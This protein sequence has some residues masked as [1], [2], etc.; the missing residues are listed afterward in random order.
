MK[1]L[2]IDDDPG[3]RDSLERLLTFDGHDVQAEGSPVNALAK[4]TQEPFDLIFCDVQMPDLTGPDFLRR[5]KSAGGGALVIMMSAYSDEEAAIEAMEWGAYDYLAKPFRPDQLA[6]TIRQAEERELLKR[7]LASLEAELE[8]RRS[9]EYA[10]VGAETDYTPRTLDAFERE[11]IAEALRHH[12]GNRTHASRELGIART[13][14][15]KKIK[16]YNL[17]A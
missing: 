13:T 9:G 10:G 12:R 14:L 16:G 4:A 17:N 1:L 2:I 11:H 15:I 3:L 5:Y 6:L 7:Q 8:Q